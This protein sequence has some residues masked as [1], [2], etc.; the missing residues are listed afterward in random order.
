MC[1]VDRVRDGSPPARSGICAGGGVEDLFMDG[2]LLA[3]DSKRVAPSAVRVRSSRSSLSLIPR[4][5]C[6][7]LLAGWHD[8]G[9]DSVGL[10][11]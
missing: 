6:P 10:P 2:G 9:T 5:L 3:C 4:V 7:S 11:R 8:E 1:S